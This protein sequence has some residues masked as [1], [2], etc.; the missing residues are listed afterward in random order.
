LS[1]NFVLLEAT[2]WANYRDQERPLARVRTESMERSV[3]GLLE[4]G[5]TV[6]SNVTTAVEIR[7][8]PE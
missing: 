2:L 7:R 8:P 6:S 3:A 1:D 4:A 5:F